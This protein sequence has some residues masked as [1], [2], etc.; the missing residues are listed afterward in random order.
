MPKIY[1]ELQKNSGFMSIKAGDPLKKFVP[2]MESHQTLYMDGLN[3]L[4]RQSQRRGQKFQ[5][6]DWLPLNNR[7]NTCKRCLIFQGFAHVVQCHHN[8]KN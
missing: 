8:Q 7:I 1:T 5:G 4:I 6:I 3:Y 2:R